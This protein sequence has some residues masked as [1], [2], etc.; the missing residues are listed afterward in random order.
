MGREHKMIE[1]KKESEYLKK[2]GSTGSDDL[3]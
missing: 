2:Y 3:G 1:P